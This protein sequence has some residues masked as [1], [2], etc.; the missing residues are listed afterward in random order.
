MIRAGLTA[1]LLLAFFVRPALAGAFYIQ[2]QSVSSLGTAFA[3]AAA[4]TPDAS[5]IFFNPAGM[6]DLDGRQFSIGSNIISPVSD[7]TDRGSTVSSLPG[8]GGA[9]VTLSGD[10]GSDPFDAAAVPNIYFAFPLSDNNQ[11]W[12]GIG[13]SAPFGLANEYED[14][15]DG[16]YDSTENE[17][18]TIDV[19]PS[20]A[21]APCDFISIGFGLNLQQADA[22]LESAVPSPITAG[23]PTP[24]TDGLSDLSGDDTTIGF[25]AGVILKPYENTRIGV[26][27]RQ[28]ISHTLKGRLITRIPDDVPGVGGTF[29]KVGGS[30]ELDLPNI[31]SFGISQ[32]VNDRLKILFSVTWHE[33]QNF[34]DIAIQLDSGASQIALQNYRNTWAFALG[35]RYEMNE[36]LTLKA[37]VQY[38][39]TPTQDHF[40]TTRIPDG[41]KTWVTAGASYD[42]NDKLTLDV[43]AAYINVSEESIL[44]DG[45]V[46]IGGAST[47]Y[48]IRGDVE[49]SVGIASAALRYKF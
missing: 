29:T 4:D 37:G 23:G 6:T 14:D 3:G 35:A 39:P 47:T 30:A 2:E 34:D 12:A 20:I 18:M 10:N 41:D 21:Y 36:R 8:T 26:H 1:F 13:V 25:N 43:G 15:Y 22:K 5:T 7:Y 33:W 42:L 11:W 24:A 9:T 44:L 31:V 17:L 28:G 40:R 19:A 27:Y 16:R 48:N 32:Q 45:T 49:G 38:D 46:P